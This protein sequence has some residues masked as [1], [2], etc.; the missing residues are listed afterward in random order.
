MTT[1]HAVRFSIVCGQRAPW[2]VMADR[3]RQVEELGFHGFNVVDHFYGLKDVMDPTH[4]AYTILAGL[5]TVTNRV[6]LGVMVCGNT[7][8][9]PAFLLKQAVTV[10]HMSNGR[11]DFGAPGGWSGSMRHTVSRFPRPASGSTAS[12]KRSRSGN[13]CNGRSEP[14]SSGSI[15]S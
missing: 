1:Q 14:P 5:A 8:R 15:T 9:N 6:R 3:A 2:S 12:P 10:D 11:V 13:C 4:E 7:Y